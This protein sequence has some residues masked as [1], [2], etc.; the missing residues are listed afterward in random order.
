MFNL[1]TLYAQATQQLAPERPLI[2]I[3]GN[4]G[5]KGCELAEGYYQSILR[6]GA[7][8]LVVPPTSELTA[9]DALLHR[10]DGILLSGGADLNPLWVGE[11][12]HSALGGINP[13]RDAFELLLIR[14]AADRGIA[15]AQPK[16][17]SC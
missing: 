17:S 1:E 14:R 2:A 16:R 10:V 6:A 4:F 15:Q 12:P 5:D 7:T 13:L 11:E 9:I 8:P 3:T